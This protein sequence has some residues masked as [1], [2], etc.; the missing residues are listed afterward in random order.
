[1]YF[2]KSYI[3]ISHL[4]LTQW[5]MA[6]LTKWCKL[7][8]FE[9]FLWSFF[10]VNLSLNQTLL[11]FLLYM[12]QTRMTQLILVVSLCRVILLQSEIII[13]L[14]WLTFQF[15]W[16]KNFVL[17]R[18]LEKSADSYVCFW[19]ALLHSYFF[20]LYWSPFLSLCTSFCF[21]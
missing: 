1:M 6:I 13:K 4:F 7:D 20:F 16:M 14:I 12:R 3:N 17:G 5:T 21:L 2:D 9:A 11:I 15:M 8:N 10:N 18:T 19:V